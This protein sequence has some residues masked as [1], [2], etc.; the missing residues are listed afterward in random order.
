MLMLMSCRAQFEKRRHRYGATGRGLY[1]K[2]SRKAGG[3]AAVAEPR[4][5]GLIQAGLRRELGL[6]DPLVAEVLC[7]F[8]HAASMHICIPRS[9]AF[10]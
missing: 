9:R 1:L 3:D 5:R 4:N 6:G 8:G 2:S 7:E 10:R